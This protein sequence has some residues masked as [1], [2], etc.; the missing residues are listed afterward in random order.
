LSDS[1]AVIPS[2]QVTSV[3]VATDEARPLQETLAPVS[4]LQ[5]FA[6]QGPDSLSGLAAIEWSWAEQWVH[7]LVIGGPVVWV[8]LGL[9]ILATAIVVSKTVQFAMERPENLQSA[10]RALAAWQ[11]GRPEEALS[12]LNFKRVIDQHLKFAFLN[13]SILSNE[14]L[15]DELTRA[16]TKSIN[17]LRSGLRPL[18]VIGVVS[19]LL[20]L[21]GT[22]LGMIEAFRQMEQAGARVDPSVLSG[23]IWMALLTTAVGLIVALPAVVAHSWLE[24]K[25][26]RVGY[27]WDCAL[28]RVI[29][30]APTR[31]REAIHLVK[32]SEKRATQPA[33]A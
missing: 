17:Q 14:L 4:D 22:V 10:D 15:T 8:L 25:I 5:S 30:R 12:H 9:S 16:A 20:G 7:W 32:G 24:R 21:L 26:E 6:D 19:P 28:T 31:E 13:H 18:E 2:S 3:L 33:Q 23:G 11:R 27:A 1:A 29:T